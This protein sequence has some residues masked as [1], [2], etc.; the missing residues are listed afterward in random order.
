MGDVAMTVPVI[1]SLI[2]QHNDV[3]VTVVSRPFFKPF[4][5][6]MDRVDFFEVDLEDRH[7]G[8]FG[9]YRLYKDLKKLKIDFVADFHNV[10]RSK[11]LRTFFKSNG[12]K[13]AFTDKGRKEKKELT[14]LEKKVLKPVKSMVDRHVDTLAQ[15]GFKVDLSKIS[16]PE[17]PVLSDEI[18]AVTAKKSNN[19]WIGIA[20]FAQYQTKVYPTELMQKV[21]L[22]LSENQNHKIFL[23]GGKNEL[24]SLK[25]L[26]QNLE[27]VILVA[28]KLT[29]KQELQ[30]IPHLDV[31]LSMD[32]GNAH[33]AVMYGV[34]VVTLWGNTHPFAGFV[35]F[36]QPLENSLI[37]DL[38]KYPFLPTSVYGN[39]I[40]T[41][42]QDVMQS[43][44]PEE[45]VAKISTNLYE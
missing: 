27:N 9:I 14:R 34:S 6:D 43:I 42:Y 7:K 4:F 1:R 2:Q 10:L 20:P 35:P 19:K 28:D 15:L 8:F 16:F 36:N 25:N 13:T 39:K 26:Q 44:T 37:P 18:L 17:K 3:K 22:D 45:V 33:I 41:G 24:N 31:M 32:S 38:E 29:F 23:F 40:V 5:D 30:F 11:I 21:I 12:T